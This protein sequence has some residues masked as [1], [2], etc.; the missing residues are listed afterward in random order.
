MRLINFQSLSGLLLVTFLLSGCG[1]QKEIAEIQLIMPDL[2]Y[3]NSGN[4]FGTAST[5][6]VEAEVAVTIRD[7][8]IEKVDLIDHETGFG[9]KAEALTDSVVHYQS[10]ELDA[11]SGATASSKVILK[12][13]ENAVNKSIQK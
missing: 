3:T 1:T 8:R 9:K 4:Y 13:I 11:V 2:R 12:A 6:M 10:I 5:R 7:K